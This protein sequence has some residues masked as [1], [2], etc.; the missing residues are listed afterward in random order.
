MGTALSPQ[1]GYRFAASS[2]A[3]C[4]PHA[5][6]DFLQLLFGYGFPPA[7]PGRARPSREPPCTHWPL[8]AQHRV[9]SQT[10]RPLPRPRPPLPAKATASL[11]GPWHGALIALIR[12]ADLGSG[13]KPTVPARSAVWNHSGLDPGRGARQK[14]DGSPDGPPVAMDARGGQDDS[15][16]PVRNG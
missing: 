4:F 15:W 6:I 14:P 5:A 16:Q 1:L 13:P 8:C 3:D 2:L 12:A 9:S 10:P 7:S 11:L